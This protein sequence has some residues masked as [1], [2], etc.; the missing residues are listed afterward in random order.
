MCCLI[1][2]CPDQVLGPAT[3][4]RVFQTLDVVGAQTSSRRDRRMLLS[5]IESR[6]SGG[7]VFMSDMLKLWLLLSPMDYT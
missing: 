7:L 5:R 6:M 3:R 1:T 2:A 4:Q